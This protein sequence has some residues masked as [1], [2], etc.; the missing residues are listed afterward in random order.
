IKERA[1]SGGK[2]P[3][4]VLFPEGTCTN[5]KALIY[6]KLGAFSPS[7][8]V[9]PVLVK[10]PNALTDISWVEAGPPVGEIVLKCLC[11]PWMR[12]TVEFLPPYVPSEEEKKD[13]RLYARNVRAR[14]ADHLRIPATDQSFDDQILMTKASALHLPQNEAMINLREVRKVMDLGIDDAKLLLEKFSKLGEVGKDGKLG[15]DHFVQMFENHTKNE[16]YLRKLFKILDVEGHGYLHFREYVLGVT[17]INSGTKEG[18]DS[19]LRLAFRCLDDE[20]KGGLDCQGLEKILRMGYGDSLTVE[21]AE[22]LF[23][24]ADKARNGIVTVDEFIEFAHNH[25]G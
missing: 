18:I 15:E 19:S 23:K 6:F 8:P 12:M 13:T 25:E 1:N 24:E 20:G 14:M 10:Y 2:W 7:V 9:Q 11:S 16:A 3:Q 17:L 4:T 5:G 22:K 21:Q